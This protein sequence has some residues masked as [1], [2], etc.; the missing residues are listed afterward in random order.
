MGLCFAV[1][2]GFRPLDLLCQ[3]ACPQ[4]RRGTICLRFRIARALLLGRRTGSSPYHLVRRRQRYRLPQRA[5]WRRRSR[6][7]LLPSGACL[8]AEA[9]KHLCAH[10]HSGSQWRLRGSSPA[11]GVRIAEEKIGA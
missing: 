2:D 8:P 6:N 7:R 4:I 9:D 5:I 11:A 10:S 1:R 3:T